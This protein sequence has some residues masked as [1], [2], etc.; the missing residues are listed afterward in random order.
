MDD[1]LD[2]LIDAGV[3]SPR[4]AGVPVSI[5]IAAGDTPD[6]AEL[7]AMEDRRKLALFG[8]PNQPDSVDSWRDALQA[9]E[10]AL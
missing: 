2:E 6:G 9:R 8:S 1:L 4:D 5:G 10:V 3:V 7:L